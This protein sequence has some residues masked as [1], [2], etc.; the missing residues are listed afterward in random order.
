M[1]RL[2]KTYRSSPMSFRAMGTAPFFKKVTV[3]EQEHFQGKCLEFDRG[4]DNIRSIRVE[5]GAC[6]VIHNFHITYLTFFL[7]KHLEMSHSRLWILLAGLRMVT[8]TSQFHQS[9]HRMIF[10]RENFPSLQAAGWFMPEVSSTHVQ[11]G[12]FICPSFNSS[13]APGYI[14]ECERHSGDN[15]H[16][17]NWG[18]HCQTPN[19]QSIKRIRH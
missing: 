18:S 13:R 7:L 11:S 4:L 12:K 9:S 8:Y 2:S 16:W 14:M 15:Q 3:F 5:S 1:N 10:E 6:W 19:T 17:R